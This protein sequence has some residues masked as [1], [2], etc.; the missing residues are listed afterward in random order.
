MA[1]GVTDALEAPSSVAIHAS[2]EMM[3]TEPRK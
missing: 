3:T 1:T 2:P